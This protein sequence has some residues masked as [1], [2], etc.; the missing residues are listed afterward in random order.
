MP[1]NSKK[2]SLVRVR[3]P[4]GTEKGEWTGA[5]SDKSWQWN[6]VND[7]CK[8]RLVLL[9]GYEGGGGEISGGNG[10]KGRGTLVGLVWNPLGID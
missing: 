10:T 2:V 5:W 8:N 9:A 4:W 1:Y 7:S 6:K 3:N